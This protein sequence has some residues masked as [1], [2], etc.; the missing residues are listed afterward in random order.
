MVL[1]GWQG[2]TQGRKMFPTRVTQLLH[3]SNPCVLPFPS[4][5]RLY[6]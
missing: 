3:C 5:L 6:L 1:W 4:S 2:A